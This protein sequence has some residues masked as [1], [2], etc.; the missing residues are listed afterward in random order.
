[1][2]QERGGGQ[3]SKGVTVGYGFVFGAVC[4]CVCGFSRLLRCDGGCNCLLVDQGS[5]HPSICAI[6]G[7]LALRFTRCSS[8]LCSV[9]A[10]D[11]RWK[12]GRSQGISL[13]LCF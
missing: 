7:L 12:E 6:P 9:L 5:S 3:W 13:P 11:G 8:L 4:V 1:M 2:A 10:G